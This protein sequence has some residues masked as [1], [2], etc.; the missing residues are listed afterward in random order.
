MFDFLKKKD[1]Q[2]KPQEQKLIMT[3]TEESFM[4]VR[5]YYKLHNKKSFIKALRKLKCVL[6]SDEDDNHFIISYHKEAKKIDLAVPYQ[7]VPK[8]LYPITLADGYIVGNA[9][10]R[11]DIKSLRRA[12]GLVDFLVKFIPFNIIEITAMANYNKV[13]SVRSE[14][15][16]Y[17]WFNVNYD[18][19]FNNISTTDYNAELSN[20]GQKIQDFYE[21][22][23]EEIKEKQREEFDKKVLSLKQQEIDYYPDA[24]KIALHYN[25]SAHVA[26]MNMLKFRAIIKEVVARKRYDG[27]ERFTSFDAIDDF[28]EFIEEKTLQSKFN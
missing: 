5:L 28:R 15:E 10:L 25:R 7:E 6:F 2:N 4:P 14:A 26:M 18:E 17:Q 11:I 21:S 22:S 8:E 3:S 19:L 20:I 27:D 24:E 9:E 23:D 12:V 16:Y 1:S 13:I